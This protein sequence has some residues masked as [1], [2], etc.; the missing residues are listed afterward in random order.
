MGTVER[1]VFLVDCFVS[2]R[3]GRVL[4]QP[5]VGGALW[6]RGLRWV[7]RKGRSMAGEEW[8]G[9]GERERNEA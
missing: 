3:R 4:Q 7:G 2:Q 1:E 5:K 9:E 8:S 6:G